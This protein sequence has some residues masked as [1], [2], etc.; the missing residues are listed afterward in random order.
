MLKNRLR[1]LKNLAIGAKNQVPRE[2]PC[3]PAIVGHRDYSPLITI[4]GVLQAFRAT[5]VTYSSTVRAF[6]PLA[7]RT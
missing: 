6:K 7:R 4:E 5:G 3:E 2:A 1:A